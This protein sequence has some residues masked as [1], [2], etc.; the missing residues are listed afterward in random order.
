MYI[1]FKALNTPK[2][3]ITPFL[4]M[5]NMNICNSEINMHRL[6]GDFAFNESR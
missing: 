4:H 3:K 2:Y 5:G 6:G 1:K